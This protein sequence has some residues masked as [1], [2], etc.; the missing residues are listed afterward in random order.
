MKFETLDLTL[1]EKLDADGDLEV[2][3]FNE[4]Y[5][6]AESR[7]IKRNDAII[8]AKHLILLFRLDVRE[9]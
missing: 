9:V 7:W 5:N 2:E 4:D 1:G 3:F 6:R 8:I